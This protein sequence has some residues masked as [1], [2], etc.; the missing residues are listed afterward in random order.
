MSYTDDEELEVEEIDEDALDDAD[1]D[2]PIDDDL[3]ADEDEE[4]AEDLGLAGEEF[5]GLDGSSTDY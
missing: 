3:L 4:E 2:D 5:A 1:L